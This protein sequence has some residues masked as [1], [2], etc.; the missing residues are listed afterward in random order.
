MKLTCKATD[1][2]SDWIQHGVQTEFPPRVSQSHVNR[3]FVMHK[4]L[5]RWDG[6]KHYTYDTYSARLLSFRKWP[7]DK[8]PTHES[9]SFVGF[10][11]IGRNY[12]LITN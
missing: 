4:A 2:F 9:L 11:C 7:Q 1:F 5:V 8:K 12:V 3:T 10:F 6:P